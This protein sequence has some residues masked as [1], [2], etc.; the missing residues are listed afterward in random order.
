MYESIQATCG[1][2]ATRH[3]I[4]RFLIRVQPEQ[5]T[6]HSRCCCSKSEDEAEEEA[7]KLYMLSIVLI[8][9]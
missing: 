1:L 4:P 5:L 3:V 6:L 8:L 7:G 2:L 9:C